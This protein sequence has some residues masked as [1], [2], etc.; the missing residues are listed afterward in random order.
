MLLRS[1]RKNQ[2]MSALFFTARPNFGCCDLLRAGVFLIVSF[3]IIDTITRAANGTSNCLL[4]AEDQEDVPILHC[5]TQRKRSNATVPME[6]TATSVAEGENCRLHSNTTSSQKYIDDII[7]AMECDDGLVCV[8]GHEEGD[9]LSVEMDGICKNPNSS[10]PSSSPRSPSSSLRTSTNKS[11]SVL[12]IISTSSSPT[13]AP[14]SSP[15]PVSGK[16][17]FGGGGGP[18]YRDAMTDSRSESPS[19]KHKKMGRRLI[20]QKTKVKNKSNND[21]NKKKGNNDKNEKK[22][23][24]SPR[25]SPRK[26][27]VKKKKMNNKSN[28]S[29]GG[30]VGK[31]RKMGKEG[32]MGKMGKMGKI[33]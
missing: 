32:K 21:K 27:F 23:N 26:I 16:A 19:S 24:V 28:N 4:Q 12:S 17:R 31:F 15:G 30:K 1:D 11:E 18:S 13:I 7:D 10:S 8:V 22:G 33:G 5:R 25:K 20:N 14:S 2:K 9:A 6:V 3:L 29:R